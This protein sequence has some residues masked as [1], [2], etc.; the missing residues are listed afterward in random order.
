M[1]LTA[2]DLARVTGYR[3]KSRQVDAL[4]RMRIPHR[5]NPGGHPVVTWAQVN[6][7]AAVVP[8]PSRPNFD[9]IRK[10]PRG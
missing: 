1:L 3:Q 9:A 7:T 6:G 2:A 5:V 8:M 10:G 4:R